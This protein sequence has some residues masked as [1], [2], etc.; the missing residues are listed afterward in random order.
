[1]G[2]QVIYSEDWHYRSAFKSGRRDLIDVNILRVEN[3]ECLYASKREC[4][5]SLRKKILILIIIVF[6][7]MGA[8]TYSVQYLFILPSFQTL[9]N[10][11]AIKNMD[12]VSEAIKSD[13]QSLGVSVHDWASWDDTYKYAEDSNNEF[14]EE[15]LNTQALENLE[16]NILYMFDSSNKLVWGQMSNLDK[17]EEVYFPDISKTIQGNSIF[18][19]T[20]PESSVDGIMI[21]SKGPLLISARPILTGLNKG[22]VHGTLIMGRFLN[23]SSLAEQTRINL[24]IQVLQGSKISDEHQNIAK[25][26][27]NTREANVHSDKKNTYVHKIY[28]DLFGRP[29]LLLDINIPRTIY[30]RGKTAINFSILS[31][32]GT[33]LILMLVLLISLRRM[34]LQPLLSLT[35]HALS[36]GKSG[37]LS[38]LIVLNRR[39]EFGQ[40]S[41]EFNGMV[42]RLAEARKALSEQS[43]HAGIAEMARGVLHNIGNAITPLGVKL[44]T[45]K[46]EFVKA[47]VEEMEMATA[48]LDDPSIAADRRADLSKFMELSGISLVDT[49]KTSK[50]GI[51]DALKHVDH[52]QRILA[53][54]HRIS[55]SKGVVERLEMSKLISEVVDLIPDSV[56]KSVDIKFDSNTSQVYEI[57]S[58]RIALEQVIN[59]LLKNSLESINE[60][61]SRSARGAIS[62]NV[63]QNQEA[64]IPMLDICIEDNG[65]GIPEENFSKLFNYGFSTKGRG[66]GIGLHW[67]ANTINALKGRLSAESKG[68]DKGAIFHILLPYG[69]VISDKK[70]TSIE[71]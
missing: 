35:D 70:E 61:T 59:N 22:P 36:L 68:N 28:N 17:K 38:Q 26:L 29:A 45:L 42:E 31:L 66:S 54:Q 57:Y 64:D 49:I 10:E 58:N 41:N 47:S 63:L 21:T 23:T 48:E 20:D 34:I 2:P 60:N 37:N 33:V 69:D 40:L 7:A 9:E 44:N 50:Q 67:C 6:L 8:L 12:R 46:D 27:G 3:R 53:D 16:V 52:I 18:S 56:K 5:M 14:R 30:S 51:H 11:E 43:Y 24:E 25:R 32:V 19:M 62:I 13:I 71:H 15:N 1:L 4:R 39:D 55:R 65:V